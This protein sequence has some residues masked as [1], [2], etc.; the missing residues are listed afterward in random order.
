M[1]LCLT[2]AK[3]NGE[4]KTDDEQRPDE[5][6]VHIPQNTGTYFEANSDYS[7]IHRVYD[8]DGYFS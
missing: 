6:C 1:K 7:S 2:R 8:P 3:V 5:S 4:H